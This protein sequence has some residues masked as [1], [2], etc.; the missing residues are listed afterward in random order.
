MRKFLLS[1][2]F[3]VAATMIASTA[4]AFP[5]PPLSESPTGFVVKVRNGCGPGWHRGPYGAC[6]RNGVPYF[7]GPYA[8][9]A[10]PL[11]VRCWWVGTA[12]GARRVCA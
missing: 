7:Y 12:Y 9:Y 8:V 3:A 2:A 6:R 5:V 4:D 10:P 11:P 1:T